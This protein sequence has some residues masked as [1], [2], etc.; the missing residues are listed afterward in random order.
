MLFGHSVPEVVQ[1]PKIIVKTNA[2]VE[3]LELFESM[4]DVISSLLNCEGPFTRSGFEDFN[5]KREIV[6]NL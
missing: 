3:I 6:K 5:S 1:L 4:V 2:L